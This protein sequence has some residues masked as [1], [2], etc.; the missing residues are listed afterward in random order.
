MSLYTQDGS[1]TYRSE[2]GEVVESWDDETRIRT[3]L[4]TDPPTEFP[5]SDVE[6]GRAESRL[7]AENG[8]VRARRKERA[9]TTANRL[10]VV[11]KVRADELDDDT[12]SQLAALFPPWTVGLDVTVGEVYSWDDTLVECLQAHT[13]QADWTPDVAPSLWKIHRTDDGT[14][15]IEWQAG[16]SVEVGEVVVYEGVSY[17]VI[18]SHTTQ[19]GWEPPNTPSLFDPVV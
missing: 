18:Q 14:G 2:D 12:I 1:V 17:T 9:R 6:N 5:Y 16:I 11:D 7:E 19:T 3:D 8:R 15:P 4:T 10:A 13:T